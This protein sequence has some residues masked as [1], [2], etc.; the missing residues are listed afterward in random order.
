M[1]EA[2]LP[3]FKV[4]RAVAARNDRRH[5]SGV[6]VRMVLRVRGKRWA[7]IGVSESELQVNIDAALG[8]GLVW[9]DELRRRIKSV[10]GL[11]I[12]APR[13]DTIAIRLTG[14]AAAPTVRAVPDQ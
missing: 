8:A 2:N 14:F 11:M 1:I 3:G 10:E 7:G 6:H 13:S 12:F 9:L 4:E 5:L